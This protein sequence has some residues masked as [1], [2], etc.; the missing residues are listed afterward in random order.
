MEPW[1][2][3]ALVTF[4]DGGF[5][6]VILDR[7]SLRLSYYRIVISII[8]RTFVKCLLNKLIRKVFLHSTLSGIS[9]PFDVPLISEFKQVSI[10]ISYDNGSTAKPVMFSARL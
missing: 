5:V 2:R 8:F 9:N 10:I 3:P 1:D 4:S 6:G 7:N